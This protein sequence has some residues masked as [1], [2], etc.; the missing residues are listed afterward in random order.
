M[1]VCGHFTASRALL[2][3]GESGLLEN[4]PT[5]PA[6]QAHTH[7]TAAVKNPTKRD[8]SIFRALSAADRS[9]SLVSVGVWSLEVSVCGV[10]YV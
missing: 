2:C 10:W 4:E 6:E 5:V 8:T 9:V 7:T 3:F 1:C